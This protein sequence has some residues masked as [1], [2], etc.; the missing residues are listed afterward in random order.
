MLFL[1][2]L[3]F[4]KVLYEWLSL[5]LLNL[6]RVYLLRVVA[7]VTASELATSDVAQLVFL[8]TAEELAFVFDNLIAS[9][10]A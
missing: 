2:S 7:V 9:A 10:L 1:T 4:I 3:L 8:I 5:N 6:V